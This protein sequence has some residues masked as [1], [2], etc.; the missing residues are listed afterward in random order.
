MSELKIIEYLLR[1]KPSSEWIC[2]QSN[3]PYLKLDM[4]VPTD[5]ILLE[6]QNIAIRA[7]THR[8]SDK[9]ANVTNLGWKSLSLY[10]VSSE[11]T[12]TSQGNLAWT[13]IAEHCPKTVQWL[14][15]NFIIDQTTG[16]IRFMLLEPK[17]FI[18]L[19]KD[20]DSKS[21][22][23]INIPIT[24]PIGCRF[25]FK[26]YGTVPFEQGGAFLM[27]ISNEHFVYNDSDQPRLH[28]IVHSK[29]KNEKLISE[30]YANRYYS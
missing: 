8:D 27:D 30:S 6:W 12:V 26:N 14:N 13:D 19:H 1:Y 16:R 3:L 23:E 5:D 2:K 24:N 10:G 7:V 17:G 28:I 9:Y 18:V 22:S 29:L 15:D 11:D 21:L 25:R 20:R 4:T